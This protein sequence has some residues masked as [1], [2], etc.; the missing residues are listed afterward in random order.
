MHPLL[1]ILITLVNLL[2]PLPIFTQAVLPVYIVGV[3]LTAYL[4]E[5]V[6]SSD[7]DLY[8]Y[9][10]AAGEE[11]TELIAAI[12]IDTFLSSPHSFGFR[13][14]TPLGPPG[15]RLDDGRRKLLHNGAQCG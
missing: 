13:P 1:A 5:P 8:L 2:I 3:R 7:A 9:N 11:R 6:G 12:V 14:S 4:L 10:V 15:S